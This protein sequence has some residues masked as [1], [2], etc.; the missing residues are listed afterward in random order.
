MAVEFGGE[1]DVFRAWRWDLTG[2]AHA[3]EREWIC[4]W[5][6]EEVG[7]AASGAA[8]IAARGANVAIGCRFPDSKGDA[9]SANIESYH[10]GRFV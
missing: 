9:E 10:I 4:V 1:T 7:C 8:D 2:S 5:G 3:A 6:T